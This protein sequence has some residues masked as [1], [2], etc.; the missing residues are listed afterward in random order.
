MRTHAILLK[1]NAY[2]D[3]EG[4]HPR[5]DTVANDVVNALEA[6]GYEGVEIVDQAV[7]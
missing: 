6:Y 7:R 1:M 3:D 5:K 2:P 4:I